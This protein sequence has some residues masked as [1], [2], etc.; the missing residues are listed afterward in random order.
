VSFQK[1]DG[2]KHSL[3]EIKMIKYLVVK[4]GTPDELERKVTS[5]IERGYV[6]I[7]GVSAINIDKGIM[8]EPGVFSK[9]ILFMQALTVPSAI[10]VNV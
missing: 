9:G 6:P 7:G 4:A 8:L 1:V 5:V 3:K 10:G 2:G